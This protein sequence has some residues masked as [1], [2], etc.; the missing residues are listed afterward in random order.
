MPSWKEQALEIL[1][2]LG[3]SPATSFS[4]DGVADLIKAVL[5]R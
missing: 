5:G 4:E 3:S 1:A 2:R